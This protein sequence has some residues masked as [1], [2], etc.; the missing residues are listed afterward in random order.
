MFKAIVREETLSNRVTSQLEALI[1]ESQLS[2]GDRL[3]AERDLA[4]RF[5]VSRTVVREAVRSL[6]AKGMVE[7]RPGSGTLV[8]TPSAEA[9]TRS[10]TL[11]LRGAQQDLDYQKGLEGRRIL[12]VEIAGLAATR[13]TEQDLEELERILEDVAGIRDKR[14]RFVAWD[15]GF[16]TALAL[17][18]HN[19][20]F[21]LL[22]DSVVK[23]MARV[24]E[25]GFEVPATP[26]RAMKHHRAILKQVRAKSAAG[27][28]EAMTDHLK[29]SEMTIKKALEMVSRRKSEVV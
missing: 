21:P 26:D 5:G 8:R 13:R 17:A 20:L 12:E 29:E 16:H 28:R 11:F 6:A 2:P 14:D 4:E 18:T 24:R 3:P 7:V 10:M 27:A 22:L 25:V 15:V 9:G 23:V 19:E 1:V